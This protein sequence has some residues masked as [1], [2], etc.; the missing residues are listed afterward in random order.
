MQQFNNFFKSKSGASTNATTNANAKAP[1]ALAS[2]SETQQPRRRG[3]HDPVLTPEDEAFLQT[4]T[5]ESAPTGQEDAVPAPVGDGDRDEEPALSAGVQTQGQ[6]QMPKSPIEEFGKELGEQERRKSAAGLEPS[7]SGDNNAEKVMAR[8][9]ESSGDNEKGKENAKLERSKSP[10]KKRRPW[11][12]IWKKSE[13]KAS[14]PQPQIPETAPA[15]SNDSS[16]TEQQRE[17]ADMTAILDKLN[18]AADNN[19]VFSIS[20]ETQ[21]LLR[22][23][24]LIFKD[25]INGVPT[26]YHDLEMLLTNGNKQLQDTYSNLPSFLQKLIERLPEKWTESIAPEMIAVA[27]E[28]ASRS[29]VNVD[30][31]GKAAA[32]ANKM[33]IS[34]PSLKELVGKPAAIVGMLRS[35]MAFL[36][37]RFPAVLGMNVLWSLALFILLFVLWYCHKR[38]REARLENER[39]VTEEEIEKMNQESAEGTVAETGMRTETAPP[40]RSTETLTTTA[41]QGASTSEVRRG[42]KEAQ[43]AQEA[44][45]KKTKAKALAAKEQAQNGDKP[46][47]IENEP[48]K[49]TR[50]KSILSIFGR[51]GSQSSAVTE[52]KIEPYPGT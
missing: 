10:E 16:E 47:G 6:D 18:L 28:R 49:P 39:L 2:V 7:L 4:L 29:G 31:I 30:N 40:I 15:A 13:K 24:K 43:E 8:T 3:S 38:G 25:L 33:G 26:A 32:A 20:D 21:E 22:K 48:I 23:F 42:I 46:S 12:M 36:R 5:A 14:Q 50:S 11:S 1:P 41:A 17:N 37:A 44:R 45:E 9:G 27:A 19:R 34:V 51:S 35:I 52:R